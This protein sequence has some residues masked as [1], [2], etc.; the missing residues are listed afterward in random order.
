MTIKFKN[1][2]DVFTLMEQPCMQM[3]IHIDYKVMLE[4]NDIWR[5][6]SLNC[7]THATWV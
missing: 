6:W 4:A 7:E 5:N 1:T 2:D 3:N